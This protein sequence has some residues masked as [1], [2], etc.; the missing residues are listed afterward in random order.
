LRPN[1]G[2]WYYDVRWPI[3]LTVFGGAQVIKRGKLFNPIDESLSF[4]FLF[5]HQDIFNQLDIGVY[6]YKA[7][8]MLGIWYRGLPIISKDPRGDAMA[9]LVGYK[10]DGIRVGYSYDFTISN[11]VS[12]TGGSHEISVVYEFSSSRKKKKRQ[13]VPCPEF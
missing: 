13:M 12:S 11:L 8:L 3:K 7:P 4:A 9:F 2:L 5:K 1:Y 6:W 10:M